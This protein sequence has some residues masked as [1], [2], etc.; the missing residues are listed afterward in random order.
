M[1]PAAQ[2]FAVPI[3]RLLLGITK[4]VKIMRTSTHEGESLIAMIII[5]R[6]SVSQ[7]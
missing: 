4:N 6:N 2:M 5:F 3:A 7:A 1:G